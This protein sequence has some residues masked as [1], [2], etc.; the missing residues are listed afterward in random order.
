MKKT[1]AFFALLV[2]LFSLISCA[3]TKPAS[4]TSVTTPGQTTPGQ[5]APPSREPMSDLEKIAFLAETIENAAEPRILS[6]VGEVT[7]VSFD[8][9][10]ESY[11]LSGSLAQSASPEASVLLE[12]SP[13][14]GEVYLRDQVLYLLRDEGDGAPSLV[15]LSELAIYQEMTAEAKEL[16]DGLAQLKSLLCEHAAEIDAFF[17]LSREK[18]RSADLLAL[19]SFLGDFY[20][21]AL[22]S[23][24]VSVNSDLEW[25]FSSEDAAKALYHLTAEEIEEGDAKLTLTPTRIL[26]LLSD[27]FDALD[28]RLDRTVASII[29]EYLG[30]GQASELYRRLASFVGTSTLAAWRAEVESILISKGISLDVFYDLMAA[31]LDRFMTADMTS[32]RLLA[33]LD[34]NAEKSLDSV[35]SLF[36]DSKTYSALLLDF[37][38]IL[39]M[40]PTSIYIA[41]GGV[42][43]LKERLDAAR[44]SFS[45]YADGA[46]LTLSLSFDD[47]RVAELSFS[48]DAKAGSHNGLFLSLL[49]S[50]GESLPAPSDLL[51]SHP[52]F[53]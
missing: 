53:E 37:H 15:R 46:T 34:E 48:L 45:Q 39:S 20:A 27:L 33:L 22:D 26:A 8:G 1:V 24:G 36:L 17:G 9:T 42:G 2:L 14:R 41:F 19:V 51:L 3:D 29:D 11:T 4:T 30:A 7:I 31:V 32:E 21:K 16:L 6:L 49:L 12:S 13:K 35:C 43:D 10:E 52:D 23:I 18:L 47:P 5:T 25:G 28:A 50:R 44:A 38:S 40:P